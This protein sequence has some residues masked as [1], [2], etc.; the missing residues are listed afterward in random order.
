MTETPLA[1]ICMGHTL[2]GVVHE[3]SGPAAAG[4]VVVVGGPQYRAGS[5]RH[6]V[7]MARVLA[8]QGFAVLRFDPRGSGDSG[9]TPRSFE[10]LDEDIGAAIDALLRHAPHLGQVVLLGLCD[11]ASAALMYMHATSDARVRG[12]CVLNP[13]V[14]SQQ[15]LARTHVKHYYL[16]RMMQR[17]FW[18]KL[19][20]GKVGIQ[21]LATLFR[22]LGLAHAAGKGAE[23][24]LRFQQRMAAGLAQ[25]AGP[26]LLLLSEDDYTAKEFV[27]F[28]HSDLA[29]QAALS[30]RGLCRQVLP[31]ADHTLSDS[32]AR[33]LAD[34]IIVRWLHDEF[35]APCRR[36]EEPVLEVNVAC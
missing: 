15:S 14:R 27:E 16:R 26:V 36:R 8:A 11:G 25:F 20:A 24:G 17:E 34:A 21:A 22:N 30:R 29:W 5:H 7:Q 6:F 28:T 18:R 4:V 13:W 33:T 2:A 19:A 35:G 10:C 3:P 1:F 32:A 9:G 12:L 31:H 23:G